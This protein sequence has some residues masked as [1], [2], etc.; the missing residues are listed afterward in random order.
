MF[1][2]SHLCLS[3][4]FLTKILSCSQMS[5]R[6]WEF[7]AFKEC[8]GWLQLIVAKF[9]PRCK[10]SRRYVRKKKLKTK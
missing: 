1:N 2:L 4:L 8:L 10:Y 3:H 9:E 6:V 7:K 5:K